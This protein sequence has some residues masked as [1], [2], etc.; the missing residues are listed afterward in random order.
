MSKTDWFMLGFTVGWL[1]PTVVTVSLIK[2]ILIG[3]K[4]K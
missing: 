4:I 1:I 2:K 3:K